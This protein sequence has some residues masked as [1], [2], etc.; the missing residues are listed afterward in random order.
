MS[1]LHLLRELIG[2]RDAL[3]AERQRRDEEHSLACQ[4][5][6]DAETEYER[7]Y[8]KKYLFESKGTAE[9]RKQQTK[10]ATIDLYSQHRTAIALR[11]SGAAALRAMEADFECIKAAIHAVN[12]AMK[13][14]AEMVHSG[15]YGA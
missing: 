3:S 12:R 7:E 11:R 1:D 6:A 9:E 14:E 4:A 2:R 5:E 15:G 13:V 10:L 8:A